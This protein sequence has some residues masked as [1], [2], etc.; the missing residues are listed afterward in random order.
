MTKLTVL[1]VFAA[2]LMF[3]LATQVRADSPCSNA[4]L[5]GDYSFVASGTI[6]V[7]GSPWAHLLRLV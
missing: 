6:N 5:K 2:L 3:A 4:D 1:T 7:P